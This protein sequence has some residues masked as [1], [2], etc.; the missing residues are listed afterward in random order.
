[1][2]GGDMFLVRVKGPAA[3]VA[4]ALGK[5]AGTSRVVSED[6]PAGSDAAGFFIQVKEGADPRVA[7][8]EL[9]ASKKWPLL[10]LRPPEVSLEQVFIKLT[11]GEEETRRLSQLTHH[12]EMVGAGDGGTETEAAEHQPR[13]GPVAQYLKDRDQASGQQDGR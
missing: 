1:V 4:D 6:A 3:E 5:L 7:L 8:F 11:A 13:L 2:L 10:E 12:P 9:C